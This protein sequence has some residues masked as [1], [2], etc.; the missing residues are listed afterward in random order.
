MIT[1]DYMLG[2]DFYTG[3]EQAFC[4]RLCLMIRSY[5]Y[6]TKIR[7]GHMEM[8]YFWNLAD[9]PKLHGQISDIYSMKY[10]SNLFNFL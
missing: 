10:F 5:I 2:A 6:N 9:L 1:N 4:I 8:D 3:L 7:C